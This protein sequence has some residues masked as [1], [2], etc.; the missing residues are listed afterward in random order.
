MMTDSIEH[1]LAALREYSGYVIGAG[2]FGAILLRNRL[3][4]RHY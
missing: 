3:I 1:L 2:A 4:F